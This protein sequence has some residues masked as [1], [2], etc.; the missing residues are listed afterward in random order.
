M[1]WLF[2]VESGVVV[3]WSQ[4]DRVGLPIPDLSPLRA[5][6]SDAGNR[7][8]VT[9]F[10]MARSDRT[11]EC[12]HLQGGS[13]LLLVRAA[14]L[15]ILNR[16]REDVNRVFLLVE[17]MKM[18]HYIQS[19]RPRSLSS[20]R[21][22]WHWEQRAK[23]P[24]TCACTFPRSTSWYLWPPQNGQALPSSSR[25]MAP[26]FPI[27]LCIG[28]SFKKWCLSARYWLW[29][30]LILRHGRIFENTVEVCGGWTKVGGECG[31]TNLRCMC[32]SEKAISD[33]CGDNRMLY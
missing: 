10:N 28:L 8:H 22:R 16:G 18:C 33:V 12:Q 11:A 5:W 27:C 25:R 2:P 29:S 19:I 24:S 31:T 21:G 15:Y 14:Q 7:C 26:I 32:W 23:S 30:K 20:P 9:E 1:Q 6:G 4:R 3:P 13:F 17:V